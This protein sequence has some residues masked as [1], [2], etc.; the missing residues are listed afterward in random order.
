MYDCK[1]RNVA[2]VIG[3]EN[4]RKHKVIA[5]INL[6]L[7]AKEGSLVYVAAAFKRVIEKG[8]PIQQ[9]RAIE[10]YL[11]AIGAY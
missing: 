8:T 3:W 10:V 1:N 4:L 9:L 5:A 6:F 11:K 7:E 2:G